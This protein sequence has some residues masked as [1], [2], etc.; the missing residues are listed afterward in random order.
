[1]KKILLICFL[2][3]LSLSM[4][5][6]GQTELNYGNYKVVPHAKTGNFSLYFLTD[7]LNNEYIPLI[8]DKNDS[9]FT[10]FSL[11]VKKEM[12]D[13][14]PSSSI[15]ITTEE[16][17]DGVKI[18]YHVKDVA[19]V[20][21]SLIVLKDLNG[22]YTD[23]IKFETEIKNISTESSSFAFKSLFDT[24]LGELQ[25]TH[26]ATLLKKSIDREVFF[27]DM[28]YDK[29]IVSSDGDTSLLFLLD[30]SQVTSPE[31]ITLAARDQFTRRVWQPIVKPER[32]FNTPYVSNNSAVHIVWRPIR[33]NPGSSGTIRFYLSAATDGR[34][35]NAS[36][37]SANDN[38]L[39]EFA[40]KVFIDSAGAEVKLSESQLDAAYIEALLK[41]I[42]DLENDSDG[43]DLEEI[44]RI[45]AELDEILEQLES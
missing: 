10:S 2:L 9:F 30:G 41:R 39:G 25:K 40:D 21:I 36:I 42:Y 6:S 18:M 38:S 19:E 8:E 24:Y 32:S 35:P 45:N 26:F 33:L 29:W 20:S 7:K 5:A 37:A 16:V 11:L 15:T 1:M 23:E 31:Q 22:L 14:R 17:A 34:E 4:F 27:A 28:S 13:L 44:D 3:F 43:V 12:Y